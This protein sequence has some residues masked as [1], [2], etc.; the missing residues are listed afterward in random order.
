MVI[1][2][3]IFKGVIA[4]LCVFSAMLPIITYAGNKQIMSIKAAKIL[5][6]RALVETIYGL[7]IRAEEEVE[8]MIAANFI[9]RTESKTSALIKGIN[10][11]EIIYDAD[12]DLAKV[13]AS[14]SLPSITNID[15]KVIDLQNKVFRR[16]AFATSTPLTA[17]PLQAL[18]A[19]EIDAYKEMAKRLSGFTLESN[20]TVENYILTSDIVKT[21]LLATLYLAEVSDYGFKENGNAYVK[22]SLNIKEA[23]EILGEEIIDRHEILEVEGQGAQ[24]DD[25]KIEKEK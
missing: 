2:S 22:L 12:N 8:N 25:F 13:T 15:G 9:G 4:L 17:G 1:K 20:T 14:I 5:A 16:I 18:R 6:E 23:S 3:R 21:K 24:V 7:K 11:E 10:F 19:A